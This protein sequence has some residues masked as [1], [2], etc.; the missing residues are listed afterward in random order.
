MVEHISLVLVLALWALLAAFVIWLL[1]NNLKTGMTGVPRSW[2]PRTLYRDKQP[3]RYWILV[4][5][6][7]A[8]AVYLVV[9]FFYLLYML[10]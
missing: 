1:V 5:T 3:I 6:H 9:M 10:N 2:P 4:T 8:L 7:G